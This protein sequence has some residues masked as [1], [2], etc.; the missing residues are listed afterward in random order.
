EDEVDGAVADQEG[1]ADGGGVFGVTGVDGEVAGDGGFGDAF[2]VEEVGEFG[3]CA[4]NWG[5]LVWWLWM[6]GGR[7]TSAA[8]VAGVEGADEEGICAATGGA[9]DQDGGLSRGRVRHG[10]VCDFGFGSGRIWK[11]F[12]RWR[13]REV[14]LL[15]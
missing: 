1:G 14:R 3:G 7:Q 8:V 12:W 5:V 13:K 2:G 10:D 6:G 11:L 9:K 4:D 15:K